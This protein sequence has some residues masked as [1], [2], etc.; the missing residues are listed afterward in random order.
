MK[1]QGDVAIAPISTVVEPS[2]RFEVDRVGAGLCRAVHRDRM[3][4]VLRD[5]RVR[6]ISAVLLSASR[7]HAA[8]LT[9]T[10]RI[11]REFPGVPTLVLVGRHGGA[12]PE[13]LLAIGNCGVQQIVDVRTPGGWSKLR[14]ILSAGSDRD[15]DAHTAGRLAEDLQG[16]H[17]DTQR[18]VAALFTG[19]VGPRTVKSLSLSL[20]VLPCTL[21]SRFFRCGLPAPKVYLVYAGLVRA[22]RL[23]E[24]PGMSIADVANHLDHSS[25]QSFARHVRTYLG[26]TAGE[27]RRVHNGTTMIE[28]FRNDLLLPYLGRLGELS[29]IAPR[30]RNR[31]SS[32]R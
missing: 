21:V 5:L 25:P 10:A 20:G 14:D 23:L 12:T 26:L 4:D 31:S 18:F 16:V 8:E 30:P 29:P 1:D 3:T 17:A 15:P 28:K 11:V 2:E 6:R 27:F 9:S 32:P 24:N 22:A 7:C 13:G 19:Y